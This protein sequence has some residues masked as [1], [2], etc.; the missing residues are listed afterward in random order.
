MGR[1]LSLT[2]ALF[3]LIQFVLE[4]L[5]ENRLRAEGEERLR[6]Q[7]EKSNAEAYEAARGVDELVRDAALDELRERM[8]KYQRARDDP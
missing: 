1:F 2:L 4:R 6:T 3:Q 8:R 5:R 7:L